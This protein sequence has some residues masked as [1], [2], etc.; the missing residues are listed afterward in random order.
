[1]S[2]NDHSTPRYGS[3]EIDFGET[4]LR[5]EVIELEILEEICIETDIRISLKLQL[6]Q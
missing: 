6:M 5:V 4:A 3:K 1:V 2:F